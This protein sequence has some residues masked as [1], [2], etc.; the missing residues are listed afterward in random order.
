MAGPTPLTYNGLVTQVCLLA[1]YQYSL[2]SGVVTPLN[3]PEFTALIPQ[4]L[5]YAEQRI[6]RDIDLFVNHI[7]SSGTYPLTPGNQNL[8]IPFND[9]VVIDGM[10]IFYDN[11]WNPVNPV[12]RDYLLNVWGYGRGQGPPRVFAPIGGAGAGG[13]TGNIFAFGPTPDQT[14]NVYV[15]GA[16]RAP[17]LASFATGSAAGTSTTWISTWLPDLLVMAC[18]IYVSAYQRDFGRQ[19]DDPQMALSYESQYETLLGSVSKE[20]FRKRF[21]ADAWSSQ[22]RS[23]VATPTR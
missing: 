9:F 1:P 20:E 15:Y 5:N 7:G 14:Y 19:S 3:Q 13:L 10:L 22:S 17:S 2:V 12:S 8:A 21:E 23:P 11:Q 6:Q 16:V 18:M 4:M